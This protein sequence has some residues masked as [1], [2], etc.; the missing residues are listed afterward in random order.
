MST[1][2]I[3]LSTPVVT[4]IF[5]QPVELS[6]P[7]FSGLT[8]QVL[9]DDHL[10][11]R[12]EELKIAGNSQQGVNN[13]QSAINKW[14]E[15]HGRTL[16]SLVDDDFGAE[17]KSLLKEFNEHLAAEGHTSQ[18]ASDHKS[19]LRRWQGSWLRLSRTDGLPQ[20]FTEALKF[21]MEEAGTN[22][23][24]LSKHLKKDSHKLRQWLKGEN[25]PKAASLSFVLE[26]EDYFQVPRNTLISRLPNR[27]WCDYGSIVHGQT[28]WRQKLC[29]MVKEKYWLRTFPAQLGE[30]WQKLFTF[31]RADSFQHVT[32]GKERNI[33]WRIRRVDGTCPTEDY[34]RRS[35]S[36]FFGYLC[37]PFESDNPV[38]R[39]KGFDPDSLTLGLV[40]DIGLISDYVAFQKLRS[41]VYTTSISSFLGFCMTLLH[42]SYGYLKQSPEYGLRMGLE[43]VEQWHELCAASRKQLDKIRKGIKAGEGFQ[44]CRDP[45][46]PIEKILDL[47]HPVSALKKFARAVEA[48]APASNCSPALK[49]HHGRDLFLI[50]FLTV[51]PLRI[52]QVATMTYCADNKGN[53][54]QKADGSWHVWFPAWAF[55][56]EKGAVNDRPYDVPLPRSVWKDVET[57]LFVH[58]PHLAGATTCDY[59]FRPM[60]RGFKKNLQGRSSEEVFNLPMSKVSLTNRLT[61]LSQ[62]YIQDCPGFGAH[63]FRHIVA[64]EY[65]K[66]HKDGYEVAAAI[67]HDSMKTVRKAYA[68]IKPSDKIKTWNLYYE[69]L[70]EEVISSC[71]G[72]VVRKEL[73][74]R[75]ETVVKQ[76]GEHCSR[77]EIQAALKV[78][79]QEGAAA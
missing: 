35:F 42:E 23:G 13:D 71:D 38:L 77:D 27:A 63:A 75:F 62:K 47:D 73:L 49:A 5:D 52:G 1:Q 34:R 12:S 39:G 2:P 57:Y 21:L 50:K 65:I 74:T 30:E 46:E 76:L 8:Y 17:F 53:L 14:M 25:Y 9:I 45:F 64:T 11:R 31:F 4:P 55:K 48:A 19:R 70:G 44:C 67:L 56:N 54:Y 32:E 24:R 61:L 78:V 58:R 72:K 16:S 20:E 69:G 60:R 36:A 66:N 37:L 15:I 3:F 41:G 22:P 43:T 6:I 40:T 18:Y 10:H 28:S 59:V 51:N 33:P 29:A 79:M 26:L 68:R 7:L